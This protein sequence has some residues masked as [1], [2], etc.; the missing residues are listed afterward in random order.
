MYS[1]FR[2]QDGFR[3]FYLPIMK[4]IPFQMRCTERTFGILSV[5]RI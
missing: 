1:V 2:E 4:I 3:D 5:H